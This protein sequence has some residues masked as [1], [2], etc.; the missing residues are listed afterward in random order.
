MT[1]RRQQWTLFIL[2]ACLWGLI[3]STWSIFGVSWSVRTTRLAPASSEFTRSWRDR[4]RGETRTSHHR[5]N[6]R[7]PFVLGLRHHLHCTEG[8][9]RVLKFSIQKEIVLVLWLLVLIK[10]LIEYTHL[11]IPL[12][13]EYIYQL[14]AKG[15]PPF[16]EWSLAPTA[17]PSYRRRWTAS[18]VFSPQTYKTSATR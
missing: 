4:S 12:K 3:N 1:T 17:V 13:T 9:Q 6:T 11:E 14:L 2:C 7:F 18:G 10:I 15:M 8:A 16:L 5:E